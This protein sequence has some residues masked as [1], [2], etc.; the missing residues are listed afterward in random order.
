M[1]PTGGQSVTLTSQ[2]TDDGTIVAQQWDFG[3]D[4][5][6]DAEGPSVSHAFGTGDQEVL[7][8]VTD[9]DGESDSPLRT[10]PIAL[11]PPDT[12]PPD[13][14]S[15]T[16]TVPASPADDEDPKIQGSAETGATIKLFFTEDCDGPPEVIGSAAELS[17]AGI[18]VHVPADAVTEVRGIAID[19][20]NNP[21][22]CSDPIAY[23][24]DSTP[25]A[26]PVLTGSDPASP[27][28]DPSPKILGTAESGSTVRLFFTADCGGDP[29][30]T[31][32]AAALALPGLTVE[33]T[34]IADTDVRAT[35]TDAAGHT[36]PCSQ[37]L[38]YSE[39]RPPPFADVSNP[40]DG[41]F[42]SGTVDV[43]G[44]TT[45]NPFALYFVYSYTGF[46]RLETLLRMSVVPVVDGTL[47]SWPTTMFAEGPAVL[48]LRVLQG[49]NQEA[50]EDVDV[51]IDN[52]D[53]E[54]SATAVSDGQPLPGT[55]TGHPVTVTFECTDAN[56]GVGSVTAPVT[57]SAVGSSQ[58]VD[59]ACTDNAGNGATLSFGPINIVDTSA[60][61]APAP[62]ATIPPS[63]ANDN[64]PTVTG[65]AE[66]G[67]TVRLFDSAGCGG[68][69]VASGP[70]AAFVAAGV[71]VTVA[72]DT[73]T[74]FYAT[75]EDAAGNVSACSATGIEYE[76]DS[77]PPETT[78][79]S[80]PAG[81]SPDP[82]PTYT[83]AA[84]ES[85]AVFMCRFGEATFAPC[86]SPHTPAPL[87]DAT[88][89]FEAFAIDRAG[90]HDLSAAAGDALTIDTVAPAG[91]VLT[92]SDPASPAEHNTP[93]I[94]GTAEP[95]AT[96]RLFGTPDCTGP[97]GAVGAL[98]RSRLQGSP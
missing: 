36:S 70:A 25:P 88:Y 90:N 98:R 61:L 41:D 17:A 6:F 45:G 14:P 42:L 34:P 38:T 10:I 68:S 84:D 57:V 53:P 23:R 26:P 95:G 65:L 72:D 54:L 20:A 29:E 44:T 24:E 8:K 91:P 93:A 52:F 92:G 48:R 60:P 22:D 16:S 19:T 73:T 64:D 83:L 66:A 96:V 32:T 11:P 94:R 74:R 85:G 47:V 49:D 13:P 67:S 40:V 39:L 79:V 5:V 7:L 80:G 56:S 59:G 62:G 43:R 89:V 37:P 46:P 12:T 50:V 69:S 21:S 78:I 77:R 4:G 15:L 87:A 81:P 18:T 28:D 35:A 3:N 75:A 58:H 51:T 76:E 9:A 31:G 30:V 86:T 63:P 2:S 33:V 55:P 71:A 97:A 1:N 27:A 82:T